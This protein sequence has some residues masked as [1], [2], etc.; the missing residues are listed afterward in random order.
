[1]SSKRTRDSKVSKPIT[2]SKDKNF[3]YPEDFDKNLLVVEK[4]LKNPKNGSSSC[5][6][7]YNKKPLK[8]AFAPPEDQ[9]LRSNYGISKMDSSAFGVKQGE[10][11]KLTY[12]LGIALYNPEGHNE[13]HQKCIKMFEDIRKAILNAIVA[14]PHE[15][16]AKTKTSEEEASIKLK[17]FFSFPKKDI[18]GKKVVDE[19]SGKCTVYTKCQYWQ[20]KFDDVEKKLAKLPDASDSQIDAMLADC[21]TTKFYNVDIVKSNPNP[22]RQKTDQEYKR[23]NTKTFPPITPIDREGNSVAKYPM[24]IKHLV[25]S[26]SSIWISSAN[27]FYPLMRL[28]HVFFKPIQDHCMVS[29][30]IADSDS[31]GDDNDVTEDEI[32]L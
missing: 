21:F 9:M 29:Y 4:V 18:D 23:T 6:L 20:N 19:E 5:S 10:K 26:C 22:K 14:R 25:L 3:V 30:V 1:M 32:E 24:D 17:H 16:L 7:T 31:E 8:I 2:F 12:S 27:F 13:Y 28:E 11:A 15:F